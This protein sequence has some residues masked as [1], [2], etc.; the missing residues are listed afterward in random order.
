MP[1]ITVSPENQYVN[2]QFKPVSD[3]LTSRDMRNAGQ[4]EGSVVAYTGLPDVAVPPAEM[5]ILAAYAVNDKVRET[6]MHRFYPPAVP[7]PVAE[8]IQDIRRSLA[9]L[10]Q[11]QR[12]GHEAS[13][14][15]Q[16]SVDGLRVD[17]VRL[18]TSVD[19]L[20]VD[21]RE[22]QDALQAS[23][24]RLTQELGQ[25][26]VDIRK[27]RSS[28]KKLAAAQRALKRVHRNGQARLETKLDELRARSRD[29]EKTLHQMFNS[30]CQDGTWK[31]YKR[32]PGRAG[33]EAPTITSALQIQEADAQMLSRWLRV[34]INRPPRETLAQK[35]KRLANELGLSLE[36]CN[37]L[38]DDE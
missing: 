13:V 7:A 18:Q 26:R 21:M 22:G 9:D 14:H 8:D 15:L 3:P 38:G 36:I 25:L 35:R 16:A 23:I 27:V 28:Q 20:R 1:A 2:V 10:L 6:N 5:V 11:A 4:Y 24:D 32:V 29:V 34:Y 31:R 30:T 17:G 33:I 37:M 12:V 19:G